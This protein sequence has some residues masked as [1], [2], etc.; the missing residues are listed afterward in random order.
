MSTVKTRGAKGAREPREP[1]LGVLGGMGPQA[2]QVFYQ[3]VLDRTEAS[4][5]QEH[6]P[7]LILS[8]TGVPDRTASILTGNTEPMYQ[9]LLADARL[10]EE[11]GCTVIAIPCNTSHYFVDRI[12]QEIGIPIL[13][14]I[15][16]TA[17]L[18][19]SQGRKRPG[20]LATDGTIQT[21]L[22]Q[23]EFAAL[24]LEP[25][26]PGPEAQRQIM[27]LIYDD[28]KAG[29][30]G[31]PE[32]FAAAHQ[33]LIAQGCDCAILACTEL[34]VFATQHPLSTFFIDAMAVLAERAVQA[35]RKPLRQ[36]HSK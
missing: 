14:M 26:A 19:V 29:K 8:D 4:C 30:P 33:D 21:G 24:G 7:A 16:E 5:D 35:C 25:L 27:S 9:R 13:H 1:K 32:K 10:L 12:Q 6:L 15:R 31:D 34:S 36:I 3:Y 28:I 18:L 23:R 17:R 20:I 2:T 22:Y 11:C